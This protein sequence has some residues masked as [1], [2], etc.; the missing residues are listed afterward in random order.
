LIRSGQQGITV[1]F[2]ACSFAII[3]GLMVKL[4]ACIFNAAKSYR[5]RF[6]G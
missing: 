5:N 3:K 4:N 1:P 6:A 2:V